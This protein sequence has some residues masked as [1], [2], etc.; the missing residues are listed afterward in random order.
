M[1]APIKFFGQTYTPPVVANRRFCRLRQRIN[2]QCQRLQLGECGRPRRLGV[3]PFYASPSSPEARFQDLQRLLHNYHHLMDELHRS[4]Q[5]Y[6]QFFA[7]LAAGVQQA[8]ADKRE[9]IRRLE[10]ERLH[11][12]HEA[13]ALKDETLKQLALE[14]EALLFQGVQ[15]LAQATLLLLRKI[16]VCQEGLTRLSEDQNLQKLMLIELA[17]Y[18]DHHRQA[19]E[20]RK[21]IDRIVREV[22]AMAEIALEFEGY[23]RE[24]LG[25][26]QA[27]LDQVAQA[28]A[29][30]HITVMEIE[31]ISR[32]LLQE[33]AFMGFDMSPPDLTD[34]DQ[35]LLDFLTAG[36]LQKERLADVWACLERQEALDP[37]VVLMGDQAT[38]HPVIDALDNLQ[39]LAELSLT[40]LA[41]HE[42]HA[43]PIRLPTPTPLQSPST[44]QGHPKPK[45]GV[46]R[47][48]ATTVNSFSSMIPSSAKA[49]N[50]EFVFIQAGTFQMGSTVFDDEQPIHT[51]HIRQ[52]FYLGK[53]PVTQ[54]QWGAV[55]DYNPSHFQENPR[56]PVENV[57]WEEVQVFIERLNTREGQRTY[58]L[59]TEAEWE[60]AARAGST[61]NYCF[62]NDR[63]QLRQYAWYEA[64]ARRQTHPVGRLKPTPWGLYDIYGNIGEWV[65]DWYD[66]TAYANP[67][68]LA[69]QRSSIALYRV[70]RGGGWD[71]YLGDCR[72]A[73]RNVEL[74]NGRRNNIG[75]RLL[76]QL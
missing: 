27:L 12:Y 58:R 51:V 73:S 75:F 64:N 6:Q 50:L 31:D 18:L 37:E 38:T 57:S 3:I 71:C 60:F 62:G 26:L 32:R 66:G 8:L 35:R 4:K 61:T 43:I 19:Y 2:E 23:I 25:P 48:F 70:V 44:N 29:S 47:S 1:T 30:L 17:G 9:A 67:S 41:I 33:G 5:A 49:L 20:R 56:Q 42:Q 54:A 10:Q 11:S 72:S 69:S 15:L 46:W 24:H 55:M 28:D 45:K 39:G 22:A 53:Y 59:P 13:V 74:P 76:R 21:R 16:V 68:R 63:H 36:Q 40:P 34:F 7:E 65:Q 14:D 52:P